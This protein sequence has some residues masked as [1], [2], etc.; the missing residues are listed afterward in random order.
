MKRNP[1]SNKKFLDAKGLTWRN[2]SNFST[3]KIINHALTLGNI[4]G[5][6]FIGRGIV[7]K[8]IH[9]FTEFK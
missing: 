6:F 4:P 9:N 3:E 5:K 1:N 8:G 2:S 7:N